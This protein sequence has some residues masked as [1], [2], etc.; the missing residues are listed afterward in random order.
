MK[1]TESN[2]DSP[3]PPEFLA[4]KSS[5]ARIINEAVATEESFKIITDCMDILYDD[6]KRLAPEIHESPSHICRR[7]RIKFDGSTDASETFR[8]T[9][10]STTDALKTPGMEIESPTDALETP[11]KESESPTD[12]PETPGKESESPTDAPEKPGKQKESPSDAPETPGKESESPGDAPES[13]VKCEN[14]EKDLPAN[15]ALLHKLMESLSV[16]KISTNSLML[17]NNERLIINNVQAAHVIE[18]ETTAEALKQLLDQIPPSVVINENLDREEPL[19]Q[20]FNNDAL[21]NVVAEMEERTS[22]FCERLKKLSEHITLCRSKMTTINW[23][24]TSLESLCLLEEHV[25]KY[26]SEIENVK[27]F[28]EA[29]RKAIPCEHLKDRISVC[30]G[31]LSILEGEIANNI[32]RI[33]G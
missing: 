14:D 1:M 3:L 19:L 25:Q 32:K 9:P 4:M 28:D 30:R 33:I 26:Q 22:D 31:E 7:P 15:E 12:A 29:S 11:G 13:S 8:A 17:S 27:I 18:L 6:Y 21:V 23:K 16:L 5:G 10:K 20:K 2:E 24:Q